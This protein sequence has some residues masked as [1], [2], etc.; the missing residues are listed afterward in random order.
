MQQFME[1]CVKV[2]DDAKRYVAMRDA[3]I[4][5]DDEFMNRVEDHIDKLMENQPDDA[6]PSAANFDEAVDVG[7]RGTVN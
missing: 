3:A 4:Q 5:Q 7:M 1:N 2:L 6:L